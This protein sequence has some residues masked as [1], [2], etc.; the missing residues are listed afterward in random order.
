MLEDA[1]KCLNKVIQIDPNEYSCF[2][3]LGSLF[4][5]QLKYEEAL[6]CYNKSIEINSN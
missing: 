2:N 1:L 5:K 3:L 4:T 6:R